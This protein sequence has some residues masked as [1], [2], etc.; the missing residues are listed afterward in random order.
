MTDH[1]AT[2]TAPTPTAASIRRRDPAAAAPKL[3]EDERTAALAAAAEA[4][5]ELPKRRWRP[6]PAQQ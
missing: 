3:A 4:R 1:T 2:P 5:A 6:G